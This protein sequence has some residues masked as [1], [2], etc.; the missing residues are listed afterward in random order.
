MAHAAAGAATASHAPLSEIDRQEL[1]ASYGRSLKEIW[2]VDGELLDACLQAFERGNESVAAAQLG[3][4]A[5]AAD[6]VTE[7]SAPWTVREAAVR[8]ETV[9]DPGRFWNSVGY[10]Y[11]SGQREQTL[12]DPYVATG[13]VPARTSAFRSWEPYRTEIPTFL[14]ENCTACGACYTV[15]PDAA[16]PATV[17]DVAGLVAAAFKQAE[18]TGGPLMQLRRIEKHLVKQAHKLVAGDARHEYRL[19]GDLLT[20]ATQA[21][22]SRMEPSADE[23]EKLEEE[24]ARLATVVE[25]FPI[26]RTDTFFLEPEKTEKGTGLLFSINV[27]ADACKSCG[28]CG[29][30]CP[31]GAIEIDRQTAPQLDGYRKDWRFASL[32]QPVARDTID[33][34]AVRDRPE[35]LAHRLLDRRTYHSMIG[36]DSSF[37]GSGTQSTLHVITAMADSVIRPRVERFVAEL[38]AAAADLERVIKEAL[39]R[40]IS[41]NDFEEFGRQL[42]TLTDSELDPQTLA[43]IAAGDATVDRRRIEQLNDALLDVRDVL[44]AYGGSETGTARASMVGVFSSD[45]SPTNRGYYPYNPFSYPWVNTSADPV[46]VAEG[47]FEATADRIIRAVG[48]LRRARLVRDD[49]YVPEE[50]EAAIAKLS[51]RDLTDEEWAVCPPVCVFAG[52]HTEAMSH[53]LRSRAPVKVFLLSS[54]VSHSMSASDVR[55]W[56]MARPDLFVLR[57]TIG[58]RGHLLDGLLEGFERR[59]PALFHLYVAEPSEHGYEPAESVN[60]MRMA[61]ESRAFPVMKYNPGVPGEWAHRWSLAGNPAP[62][63]DFLTVHP[64]RTSGS[65]TPLTAATWGLGEARFRPFYRHVPRNHW[66]GA[67]IPLRDYLDLDSEARAGRE[68]YV[69]VSGAGDKTSRIRVLPE[70]VQLVERTRSEWRLLQELAGVRSSVVDKVS[71]EAQARFDQEL[72][73][74]RRSLR[75]EFEAREA[76]TRAQFG[77]EFHSRLTSELLEMSGF[78]ESSSEAV[79]KLSQYLERLSQ[80]APSKSDA[81]S[82]NGADQ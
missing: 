59:G 72:E 42:K 53:L 43:G 20:A 41:V 79:E 63:H 66:T 50:H 56:P 52:D 71:E 35:S 57:S 58:L 36:G 67:M 74:L 46:A 26:A 3:E 81:G 24:L 19:A 55:L 76:R 77:T 39:E 5:E 10:L 17:I 4:P 78:G 9:F 25:T 12:S 38:S 34:F 22:L 54:E 32:L 31:D 7:P 68:P 23:A 64:S 51:W 13:L 16:L 70:I 61:V 33:R 44:K 8:S 6:R 2:N 69:E 18:A 21:L 60:R 62:D 11:E 75:E 15:C 40:T 30:V 47:A 45:H 37:P 14:P 29:A 65:E 1:T 73:G 48:T 27:N 80:R 49:V 28:I 82:G